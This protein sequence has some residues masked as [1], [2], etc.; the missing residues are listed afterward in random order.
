MSAIVDD[1]V[2]VQVKVVNLCCY[3][4][5]RELLVQERIPLAEPSV[6]LG[7]THDV[8][9]RLSGFGCQSTE[10]KQTSVEETNKC[11]DNVSLQGQR[12]VV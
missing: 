12:Y 7:N 6:E 11:L 5:G 8:V 3:L 1:P 9:A 2:H 4:C 10:C